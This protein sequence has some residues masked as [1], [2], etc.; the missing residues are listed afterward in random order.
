MIPGNCHEFF[1]GAHNGIPQRCYCEQGLG[2]EKYKHIMK[3]KFLQ[4]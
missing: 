3:H 4:K 2:L 1:H